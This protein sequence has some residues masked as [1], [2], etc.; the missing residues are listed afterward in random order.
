[1]PSV[2]PLSRLSV[3]TSA[4][5][6]LAAAGSANAALFSF[7]SD[8]NPNTWNLQGTQGSSG[9]FTIT[10]PITAAVNVLI[11]DDNGPRPTLAFNA[12]LVVDL[13]ITPVALTPIFGT[14]FEH[15]Y[16]V[17]GT[18]RFVNPSAPMQDWVTISFGSANAGGG[19][20]A[21]L[22]VVGPRSSWGSAGAI[23]GSSSF[24]KVTYTAS[25]AFTTLLNG[26]AAVNGDTAATYGIATGS[27]STNTDA[28]FTLTRINQGIAASALSG[29]NVQVDAND[30]PTSAWR[31]ESSYSGSAVIPAPGSAALLVVGGVLASRRRRV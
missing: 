29:G 31:A 4:G 27:T 28:S 13:T 3:I 25:S 26:L 12:R 6:L 21:R 7:A 11:D 9:A 14:T 16:A 22:S 2:R 30:L 20:P 1:M 23:F 24:G 5:V 18:V 10:S 8:T 17:N 15:V 19:D